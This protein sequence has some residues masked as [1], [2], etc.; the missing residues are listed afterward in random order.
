MRLYGNLAGLGLQP[1]YAMESGS[2]YWKSA[3]SG[4]AETFRQF[5]HQLRS[6][7]PGKTLAIIL[8]SVSYHGAKAIREFLSDFPGLKL[9]SLPTYSPEYNPT[10]QL[11]RWV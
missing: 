5:L 1:P 2:I 4:T 6:R 8:D 7:I 11:W 10:E 3:E 9:F